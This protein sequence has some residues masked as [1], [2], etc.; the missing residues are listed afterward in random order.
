MDSH[1]QLVIISLPWS[2][3]ILYILPMDFPCSTTSIC[4]AGPCITP[5]LYERRSSSVF[6]DNNSQPVIPRGQHPAYSM[7]TEQCDSVKWVDEASG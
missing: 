1:Q 4:L 3:F 2:L 5:N 7:L 6:L